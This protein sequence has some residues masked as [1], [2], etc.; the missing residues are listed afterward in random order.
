MDFDIPAEVAE[1][2]AQCRRLALEQ[3]RPGAREAELAGEVPSSTLQAVR[4]LGVSQIG[5][6][7]EIGGSGDHLALVV[8]I[9]ALAYGDAGALV[10]SDTVGPAAGAIDWLLRAGASP[11]AAGGPDPD[12]MAALVDLARSCAGGESRA[13]FAVAGGGASEI[14]VAD[15]QHDPPGGERGV[16]RVPFVPGHGPPGMLLVVGETTLACYEASSLAAEPAPAGALAA[17]GGVSVEVTKLAGASGVSGASG[18]R[19][20]GD[21]VGGPGSGPGG[22]PVGGIVVRLER[23][24]AFEVR[25]RARL[26]VGAALVGLTAASL[27]HAVAYGRDRVVF[28]TPVLGHQANAFDLA[29]ATTSLMAAQL[30]L[31]SAAWRFGRGG[32]R[33]GHAPHAAA[34]LSTIAYLEARRA[35]LAGTDLGLQ[36]LGGH[37]YM[38]DEPV[39]K[40][41]REARVLSLLWG[42]ED[43]ALDDLSSWVLNA[44]DPLVVAS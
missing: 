25:A 18:G 40:W 21:S 29:A 20:G 9:E 28:G 22:V 34:W 4:D 23:A 15:R 17:C 30:A 16:V 7:E 6:S 19:P 1:L 8:A 38:V 31:R 5:V 36:L 10:A 37:G 3:L 12:R 26:W 11:V 14:G 24:A 35:A 2:E 41:W 27:D 32:D 39:E 13:A 42:G 43:S 33:D 44:P